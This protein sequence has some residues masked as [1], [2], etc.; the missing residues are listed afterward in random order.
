[1]DVFIKSFNR[2]YYLER[3]LHSLAMHVTGVDR[4][5]VLDDG[6]P[7]P[8]LDKIKAL[9]PMVTIYRSEGSGKKQEAIKHHLSGNLPYALKNI[10]AR[11]WRNNIAKASNF[12]LL[13]EEDAW[14]TGPIDLG[15]IEKIMERDSLATTKL[16]WCGNEN[17]IRGK[18]RKI[19]QD[20]EEI[21]PQL[22]FRNP[23]IGNLLLPDKF[24]IRTLLT[25]LRILRHGWIAPFYSLYTVSSS[26]YQKAYW[27]TIFTGAS[28]GI[29]EGDQLFQALKWHRHHRDTRYAKSS[30]QKVKTS[31]ITSATNGFKSISFDFIR[32]NHRMNEAWLESRLDSMQG[33]PED[34]SVSHLSQYLDNN[35][36]HCN[37]NLWVKWIDAF[38]GQFIKSGCVI[39]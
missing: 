25:K 12:F 4:I 8:Y 6:T 38:K 10:P 17:L 30:V 21:I 13:L 29:N 37:R 31:Y 27:L 19:N 18:K 11:F 39:D 24:K 14:I 34:F 16:F 3:C 22:P 2:P 20:I 33:F 5:I 35:D 9:F 26:V 32:F 7:S 23:I 15:E 28:E 36:V 1:M